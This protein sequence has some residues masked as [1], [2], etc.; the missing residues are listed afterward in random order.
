[1][2][3]YVVRRR[4]DLRVNPCEEGF[5][6]EGVGGHMSIEVA[7]VADGVDAPSIE[8]DGTAEGS[9][10]R[11]VPEGNDTRSGIF[12][13]VDTFAWESWLLEDSSLCCCGH[14]CP[15]SS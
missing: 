13:G 10:S 5:R 6:V 8:D 15:S 2:L 7:L 11:T 12:V 3:S 14:W 1:M 4:G 9:S